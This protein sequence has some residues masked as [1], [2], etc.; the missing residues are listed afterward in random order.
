ML[1]FLKNTD[2]LIVVLVILLLG[3]STNAQETTKLLSL[4]EAIEIAVE[5]NHSVKLSELEIDISRARVRDAKSNFYPQIES[6][7]IVPFVERES[8]FFLD[9]LI[10]DFGR[11]LNLVKST[12]FELEASEYLYSQT[13]NDTIQN[14]AISYYSAL[15]NKNRLNSAELSVEKNELILFKV[16]EQN[17]LGRSSNLDLTKAK[18]DSGKTK[19]ELL[20]QKNEFEASKLELLDL[21]GADFESEVTLKDDENIDFKEYEADKS[22]EKA[23]NNSPELKKLNAEQAARLANTKSAKSEFYPEIFGR[24]AYRFEGDGGEQFPAFI[25]GI[26]FR[27][28]LFEGFA[29]FARLDIRK[30]ENRRALIQFVKTK[31]TIQSDVKKLLMDLE[32]NKEKIEITKINNS[33]ARKNLDLIKERYNLGRASRIDL[34]DA[35]LFYSES[36]SDYLEA[37]YNYKI[38]EAKLKSVVGEY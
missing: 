27:F 36:H 22:L 5:N 26:G 9:Q 34:V 21:I 10:W 8:G 37:I 30:A 19:L 18:S 15:I 12:K 20:K 25:A 6:R 35:E 1:K 2:V 14:T 17:K 38:T 31:K 4:E 3:S 29:R 23:V 16:N 13:L 24:T 11:T 33:V 32:F 28:P 7:I